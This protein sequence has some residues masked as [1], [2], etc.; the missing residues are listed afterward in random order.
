MDKVQISPYIT[1]LKGNKIYSA[2]TEH[3][4]IS[5]SATCE[6]LQYC[7]QP[8]EYELLTTCYDAFIIRQCLRDG[9]LVEEFNRWSLLKVRYAEIEI[10]SLCNWKCLYC[11]VSLYQRQAQIMSLD[12]FDKVIDELSKMHVKYVLFNIYNEP[13]LDP[14]F[15]E[16]IL[17]LA[18]K[19]MKL[20]LCT[21]GSNL[22]PSKI[23]LLKATNVL[24]SIRF[25]L[26]SINELEFNRIT[27]S[28]MLSKI[29]KNIHNAID[30][31]LKIIL[32]VNGNREEISNNRTDIITEYQKYDNVEIHPT[33]VTD[34][35]GIIKNYYNQSINIKGKLF[36]CGHQI[37]CVHIK[38]NGDLIICCADYFS[39]YVYGN[40]KNGHIKEEINSYK[41][42]NIRQKVFGD[43]TAEDNYICR[44]CLNM[45]FA[46]VVSI[47]NKVK[48]N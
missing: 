48:R 7:Y 28:N 43:I 4:I 31:G 32:L 33:Q 29:K 2:M 35:A 41:A 38:V 14:Y 39:N 1:I 15:N 27:Q 3:T 30:S 12:L 34:R 19:N 44:S 6:L 45:E 20:E 11:P 24:H 13:T 36:G 10:N 46:K 17:K 40:V 8:R 42:K 23:D 5:D 25:H 37:N 21:N 18:E 22:S 9:L 47:Q 26:P 16:R